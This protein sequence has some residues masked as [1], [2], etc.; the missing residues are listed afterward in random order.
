MSTRNEYNKYSDSPTL[1]NE[2]P[3]Y[4]QMYN[5]SRPTTVQ[6]FL[7]N[8][9]NIVHT[10]LYK[11]ALDRFIDDHINTNVNNDIIVN[12]KHSNNNSIYLTRNHQY[13]LNSL[14]NGKLM[15]YSK[16]NHNKTTSK[17]DN[18]RSYTFTNDY[19]PYKIKE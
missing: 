10:E 6:D 1:T 9:N 5:F 2:T 14:N 12:I 18:T 8:K 4:N 17:I 15:D 3:D 16:S 11:F 19:S 7:N 13:N